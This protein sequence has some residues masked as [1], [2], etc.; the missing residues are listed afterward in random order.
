MLQNN[1]ESTDNIK[2][3][4]WCSKI[5]PP[6]SIRPQ[7]NY[8]FPSSRKNKSKLS[9]PDTIN[10]TT[11]DQAS[12]LFTLDMDTNKFQSMMEAN[13]SFLKSDILTIFKSKLNETLTNNNN[14]LSLKISTE[15]DKQCLQFQTHLMTAVKELVS[16]MSQL[17]TSSPP[18]PVVHPPSIFLSPFSPPIR[19][20]PFSQHPGG[21]PWP[22]EIHPLLHLSPPQFMTQFLNNATTLPV[23]ITFTQANHQI[24][25]E[26]NNLIRKATSLADAEAALTSVMKTTLTSKTTN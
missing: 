8:R 3:S 5:K 20:Y 15:I 23:N 17:R 18:L 12:E 16:E 22:K 13:N 21:Y 7:F 2:T 19:A 26:L 4:C 11:S 10:E 25:R 1:I 14:I 6:T 24:H 9:P